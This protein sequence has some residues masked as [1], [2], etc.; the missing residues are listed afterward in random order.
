MEGGRVLATITFSG[1]EIIFIRGYRRTTADDT[2]YR[3]DVSRTIGIGAPIDYS[4]GI[5]V[6]SG[7]PETGGNRSISG[8]KLA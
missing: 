6:L 2:C 8:S 1:E 4:W 7:S 3:L 5:K